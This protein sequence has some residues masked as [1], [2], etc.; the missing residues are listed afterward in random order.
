MIFCGVVRRLAIRDKTV[1]KQR[2]CCMLY[3]LAS[4]V[5]AYDDLIRFYLNT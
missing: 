5:N 3:I 1:K 2:T 4:L